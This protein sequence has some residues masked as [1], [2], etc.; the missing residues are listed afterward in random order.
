MPLLKPTILV[1]LLFRTLDSYRVFDLFWGLSNRELESLST[2]VYEGVRISQLQFAQGNAA[3]VFIFI[4]RVL[5]R[6][7]LYQGS[8]HADFHGGVEMASAT[9]TGGG[10]GAIGSALFY[11]FLLLFVLVS[12]FPLIWIFKMS[13]INR[14]ELFQ[15]PPTILPAN[16]TGAEYA[17]I[18]ADASFQQALLNSAII[19]G[20][21]TVICLFFGSIA[22]YAIARLRFR[23]KSS[24]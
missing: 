10:R 1:A 14:A 23:F 4:N 24:S 17:Q 21:T 3:A 12:M 18:L 7:V 20:V 13:I 15:A 6:A 22:A 2:F 5:A 11:V 19:S 9:A 16:P 8:R